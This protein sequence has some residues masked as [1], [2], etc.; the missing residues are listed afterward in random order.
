MINLNDLRLTESIFRSG[1]RAVSP[2]ANVQAGCVANSHVELAFFMSCF[3]CRR[4]SQ[5]KQAAFF[6]LK[7]VSKGH[8]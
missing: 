2:Y 6:M 1:Q 3:D 7:F 5:E 4:V 8:F